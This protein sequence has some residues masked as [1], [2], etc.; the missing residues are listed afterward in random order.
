LGNLIISALEKMNGDFSRGIEEAQKI[1]DIQG[2][3]IPSGF[4]KAKLVMEFENGQKLE[5]ENKIYESNS[6][7]PE[8]IKKIYLSPEE[9]ANPKAS[10]EIKKADLIVICPGNIY[11][12]LIPNFLAKGIAEALQE[13]S[14]KVIYVCNL[15]N[16]KGQT[17]GFTLNSYV[18]LLHKYIG[19]ERIDY[20]LYNTAKPSKEALIRYEKEGEELVGLNNNYKKKNYKI[21]KANILSHATMNKK[22]ND[23]LA[24][25]RSL[26]RHDSQ[27]LAVALDYIARV[28]DVGEIIKEVV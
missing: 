22:K 19:K 18:D 21:I 6:I 26:I 3:V 9:K 17:D 1:F 7:K 11:C 2:K 10:E 15:V 5:G 4:G 16:K 24:A 20:V 25:K 28:E 14:A 27:K 12:S 8:K 13:T 23:S